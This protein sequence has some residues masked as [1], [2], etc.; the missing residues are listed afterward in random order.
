[1]TLMGSGRCSS[2][3]SACTWNCA[4]P[5][6]ITP[7][8]PGASIGLALV[9]GRSAYI[10]VPQPRAFIEIPSRIDFFKMPNAC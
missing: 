10:A 3:N 2:S 4:N 8:S 6:L 1:M 9:E 5:A 7:G